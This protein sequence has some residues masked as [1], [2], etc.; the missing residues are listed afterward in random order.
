MRLT[1]L[2]VGVFTSSVNAI[3]ANALPPEV[4]QQAEAQIGLTMPLPSVVAGGLGVAALVFGMAIYLAAARAFT[5]EGSDSGHL[6][7]RYSPTWLGRALLT[8]IGTNIIV[9]IATFIGFILLVLPGIFLMV[10]FAFVL[11]VIAVED[12]RVMESLRRSW[13][14]ARDNRLRLA[15]LLLLIGVVTGLLSSLGSLLS[16]VSPT[17][18]QLVTLVVTGP[19]AIIGYAIVADPY[20]PCSRYSVARTNH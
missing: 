4:Q 9:G 1:A 2:Y 3:A 19:L 18:G 16:I 20:R 11:F 15:A 6:T 13:A 8:A 14:L 5:R 10:S 12:A 7:G 17:V